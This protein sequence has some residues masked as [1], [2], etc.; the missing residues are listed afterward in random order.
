[1]GVIDND[2]NCF[3]FL[4]KGDTAALQYLIRIYFPVLCRYAG[5]ILDDNAAAED[6]AETAFIK[7]WEQRD[8]FPDFDGVKKFLYI[9]VRNT[10][11]NTLRGR[12]RAQHREVAFVKTYQD[13]HEASIDELLYAELLAEIR[14]TIEILPSRMRQIFLFS[15]Y[16][17]MSNQE[18]ADHFG[19]NQ[20]TVRN[21]KTRALA[22]LKEAFKHNSLMPLALFFLY[23]GS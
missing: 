6:V 10:S 22:L 7:C 1:M 20:Q 3:Q 15:Y 4:R 9:Y 14:K 17:K 19:L 11:L 18:I 12:K 16:K 2:D 21:Q 8:R 23:A 5:K 13:A